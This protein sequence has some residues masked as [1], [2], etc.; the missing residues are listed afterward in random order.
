LARTLWTSLCLLLRRR[1]EAAIRICEGHL[2]GDPRNAT[3]SLALAKALLATRHADAATVELE[4]AREIHPD[5]VKL[6]MT[7]GQ[8]YLAKGKVP[9]ARSCLHRASRIAP[10]TPRLSKAL[11]DLE[12]VTSMQKGYEGEVDGGAAKGGDLSVR[13][14]RETASDRSAADVTESVQELDRQIDAADTERNRIK[15]LMKKGAQL[16]ENGD[17]EAASAAFQAALDLDPADSIL[18]DKIENIRIKKMA[19]ALASA[20]KAGGDDAA[21]VARVKR[22]RADKLAFEVESWSRRVKDRPTDIHAH[23]EFGKRLY[24]SASVDKAIA[25]FQMTVKDPKH[26]IDSYLYLGLAFRHKRIYDM[27]AAQFTHALNSADASADR[28]LSLRHELAKTL[29]HISPARALDE[30]KRIMQ[31]DIN[32]RD[33]MARVTALETRAEADRAADAPADIPG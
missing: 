26:K 28:E 18:R 10:G 15:F 20:V 21:S 9:E 5:N 13:H 25:E 2:A 19:A 30:Y 6:L 29:E 17:L 24:Q 16:E 7:L 32:Y 31:Q 22:L 33:V 8:A 4:M 3:V 27:S 23:F 1:P 12:A 14:G 11:N